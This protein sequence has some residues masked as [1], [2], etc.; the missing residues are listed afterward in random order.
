MWRL[1]LLIQNTAKEN[2]NIQIECKATKLASLSLNSVTITGRQCSS[3]LDLTQ[4]DSV[5]SMKLR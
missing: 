2:T 3:L 4:N 5:A 1:I